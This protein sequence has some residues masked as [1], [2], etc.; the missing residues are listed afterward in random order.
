MNR[1]QEIRAVVHGTVRFPDHSEH[2]G[3]L[4]LIGGEDVAA[5]RGTFLSAGQAMTWARKVLDQSLRPRLVTA[6][7][8]LLVPRDAP[9]WSDAIV[10][11]EIGGEEVQWRTRSEARTWHRVRNGFSTDEAVARR[12]DDHPSSPDAATS[13]EG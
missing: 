1:V 11:I 5:T 3:E 12:D 10:T 8:P 6:A 2:E 9:R 7:G 4:G 13:A